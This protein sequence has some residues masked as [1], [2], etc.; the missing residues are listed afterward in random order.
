[1]AAGIDRRALLALGGVAMAA[2]AGAAVPTPTPASGILFF[3]PNSP[4]AR[5]AA[6]LAHGQ[7]LVA[8]AGDPVRQWRDGMGS[9]RGPVRGL[10]RW[11]DY[12]VLRGLAEE[13]G[14]RLVSEA[15]VA[16]AGGAMIVRWHMA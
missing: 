8:L 14:L 12:L 9:Q 1:M 7:R 4:E 5:A 15:R 13:N 16:T 2:G 11:S 3:D 10:T 6:A